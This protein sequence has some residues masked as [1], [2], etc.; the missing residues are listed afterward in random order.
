MRVATADSEKFVK[1]MVALWGLPVWP[2][3]RS[4]P[5]VAGGS[6][7]T[8]EGTVEILARLISVLRVCHQ[9]SVQGPIAQH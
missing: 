6:L 4:L 1:L 2:M 9:S 8:L 7:S 5:V 3:V